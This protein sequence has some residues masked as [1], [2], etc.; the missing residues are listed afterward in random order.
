MRRFGEARVQLSY[1]ELC[2]VNHT[3]F[4]PSE[5]IASAFGS[6]PSGGGPDA[7]RGIINPAMISMEVRRESGKS[8]SPAANGSGELLEELL[9]DLPEE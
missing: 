1:L 9:K 4:E 2:A 3:T 8:G 5:L 6:G 7:V